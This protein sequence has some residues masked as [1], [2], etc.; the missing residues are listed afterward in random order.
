MQ[1]LHYTGFTTAPTIQRWLLSLLFPSKTGDLDYVH[2]MNS[3]G[4]YTV[5]RF[6][7]FLTMWL[8]TAPLQ[9]VGCKREL[10]SCSASPS[11]QLTERP[12]YTGA[13]LIPVFQTWFTP[14][15]KPS[16]RFG[17][18]SSVGYQKTK[19][20]RLLSRITPKPINIALIGAFATMHWCQS[21]VSWYWV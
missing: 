4:G 2:Y 21:L 13:I 10:G 19:L 11:Y 8:Y 1:F 9:E 5:L 15:P 3:L 20:R 7:H 12:D 14:C 6:W 16:Y 18:S 17:I